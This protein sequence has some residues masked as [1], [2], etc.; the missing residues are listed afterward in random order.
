MEVAVRDLAPLRAAILEWYARERRNLPWR[1]THNPY[2]VLVSEVMLQQTQASRVALRYPRFV[3][4]FPDVTALASAS[5]AEVLAEWSGLAYNRRA[6]ALRRA[7]VAVAASGWPSNLR[8]LQDP[9]GVG[10]Y[11]ARAIGSPAFG[12]PVGVVGTN[13]RLWRVRRSTPCGAPP[14]PAR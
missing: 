5:E 11:T 1:G 12:W 14:F 13:V 6:L 4:R 8:T 10:A 9:P 7:A 2:A 3:A